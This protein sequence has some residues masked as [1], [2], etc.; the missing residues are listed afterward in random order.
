MKRKLLSILLASLMGL[1][2]V[3]CGETAGNGGDTGSTP[4][5]TTGGS[6]TT[7]T[8]SNHCRRLV[9]HIIA[10]A[11]ERTLHDAQK[12]TV[13]LTVIDR[14][15]KNK[16]ISL[17]ILIRDKVAHIIVE[18]TMTI[19]IHLAPATGYATAHRL[20]AYPNNL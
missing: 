15:T 16:T 13:R 3:A 2:L 10:I 5:A 9:L 11:E 20:V 6:T 1:S 7:T 4:A 19:I 14:R 17:L 18:H 8:D 12:C